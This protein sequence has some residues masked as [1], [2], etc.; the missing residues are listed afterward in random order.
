MKQSGIIRV[1]HDFVTEI[2]GELKRVFSDHGGAKW[3]TDEETEIVRRGLH[4]PDNAFPRAI[5]SELDWNTWKIKI[6]GDMMPWVC[7]GECLQIVNYEDVF[8]EFA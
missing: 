7:D 3:L 1:S 8:G 5:V 2:S 4:L 6:D